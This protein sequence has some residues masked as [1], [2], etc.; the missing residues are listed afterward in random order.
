MTTDKQYLNDMIVTNA[1]DLA[2]LWSSLM[3]VGGFARRSLQVVILDAAGR[4]APVRVPIDDIPLVPSRDEV[5][6]FGH[7]FDHLAG[8]GTPV[9]LLSRPGPSVVQEHDRQWAAALD[10]FTP[11]WP[12]HLATENAHGRCQITNLSTLEVC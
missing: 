5:D 7:F 6:S 9:V 12:V 2:A 11:R 10:S 1:R 4:P 8:Y 3:G